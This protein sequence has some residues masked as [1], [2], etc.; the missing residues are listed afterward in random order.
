LIDILFT[1]MLDWQ[2]PVA[3]IS[4]ALLFGGMTLFA[5]GFAA[6]LFTT[7][8]PEAARK[9]IRHTFPH[10]YTW[11]I[12]TSLIASLLV[13]HLN[14]SIRWLLLAIA[15]STIPTRQLLMP[16]INAASDSGNQRGFQWLHGLSVV[17]TLAHIVASA[18]SLVW[19]VT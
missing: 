16:M 19:L 6:S 1:Q 14:T 13:W 11:V 18:I 4:I 17:I 12:I 9:V 3:L 5:F 7:L 10:F 8:P 2:K 15:L